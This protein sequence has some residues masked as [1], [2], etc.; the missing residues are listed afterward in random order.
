MYIVC[1]PAFIF[2]LFVFLSFFCFFS[3]VF[4]VY[5]LP[6]ATGRKYFLSAFYLCASCSPQTYLASCTFR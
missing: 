2:L 3:L 5:L 4:N 1:N 6:V